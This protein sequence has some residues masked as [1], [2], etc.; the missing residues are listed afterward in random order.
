[1][2]MSD[3]SQSL[4]DSLQ[5]KNHQ[6]IIAMFFSVVSYVC[7]G[8]TYLLPI[9]AILISIDYV[10][11]VIAAIVTEQTFSLR[12]AIRGAVR[13]AAYIL[14]IF[15]AQLIDAVILAINHTGIV[16]IGNFHYLGF[17]VNLY[18]IGTEGLSI[19]QNVALCGMPVPP[20]LVRFFKKLETITREDTHGHQ[21]EH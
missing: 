21:S 4:T 8:I 5:G 18:L 11:G 2:Y 14:F 7:G 19:V 1:M 16:D 10:T 9:L 15:F 12:T 13:K 3:L 17:F 20:P 6:G